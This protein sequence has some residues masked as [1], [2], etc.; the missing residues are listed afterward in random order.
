MSYQ[1]PEPKDF[2]PVPPHLKVRQAIEKIAEVLLV[3]A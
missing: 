3:L 1:V 2:L